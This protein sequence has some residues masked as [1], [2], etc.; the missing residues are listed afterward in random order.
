MPDQPD[1]LMDQLMDQLVLDSAEVH[2]QQRIMPSAA[3]LA[4]GESPTAAILRSVALGAVA[5]MRSTMPLALLAAAAQAPETPVA[6]ALAGMG[7]P[8]GF[9]SPT[10]LVALGVAAVGEL[11][12]DKLPFVPARVSFAPLA[13]R[14]VVGAIAGAVASSASGGLAVRGARRGAATAA[15]AAYLG[16]FART[17]LSRRTPVPDPVWGLVE[18]ALALGLGTLALMPSL[19]ASV[20]G[21][22]SPAA[23]GQ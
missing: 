1:Q 5:G 9:R 4:G 14:L 16:Y 13:W 19:A 20:R 8:R 17:R 18:D 10:A 2:A 7:V 15:L 21:L 12:V 23:P 3:I 6:R 22:I 11:V